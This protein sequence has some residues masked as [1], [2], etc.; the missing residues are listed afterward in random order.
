MQLDKNVW[1]IFL[2]CLTGQILGDAIW[3]VSIEGEMYHQKEYLRIVKNSSL[4]CQLK[5][6]HD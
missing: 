4:Q 1:K 6:T 2:M 3:T 5:D